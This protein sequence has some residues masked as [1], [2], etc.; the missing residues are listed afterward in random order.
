MILG[1]LLKEEDIRDFIKL[2]K[3][4]FIATR[5]NMKWIMTKEQQMLFRKKSRIE[6]DWNVLIL[7]IRLPDQ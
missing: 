6:T 2:E 5:K 1:Y 7:C 4:F 3:E